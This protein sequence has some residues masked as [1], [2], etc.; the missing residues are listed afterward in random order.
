VSTDGKKPSALSPPGASPPD[1][2]RSSAAPLRSAASNNIFANALASRM[3][4]EDKSVG[5]GMHNTITCS[6][7]GAARERGPG[8]V[9]DEKLVCRY[10]NTP[11]H[12]AG[13]R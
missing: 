8:G 11:F 5:A 13:S 7:C 10:C 4:Y 12:K 3:K 2:Q 6:H 9:V 1:P